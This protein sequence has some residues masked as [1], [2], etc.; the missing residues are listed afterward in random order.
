MLTGSERC[1][2]HRGVEEV[3]ETDAHRLDA[4]VGEQL[5][6]VAIGCGDGILGCGVAHTLIVEVGNGNSVDVGVAGIAL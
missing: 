1:D 4:R 3:R 5:F 2:G 6:V